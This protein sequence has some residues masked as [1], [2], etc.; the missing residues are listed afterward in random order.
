MA[1]SRAKL[2]NAVYAALRCQRVSSR[3][4]SPVSRCA[5]RIA[6]ASSAE[7]S[8]TASIPKSCSGSASTAC[9]R[10]SLAEAGFAGS[11]AFPLY[12]TPDAE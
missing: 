8:A 12:D 9:G 5:G 4:G 6:R 10:G 3:F 2:V 7:M 11:E 1:V